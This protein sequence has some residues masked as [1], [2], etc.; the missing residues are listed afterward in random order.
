ME[1]HTRNALSLG[2]AAV[3]F[4]AGMI[5]GYD[6]GVNDGRAQEQQRIEE[7]VVIERNKCFSDTGTHDNCDRLSDVL[8]AVQMGYTPTQYYNK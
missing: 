8:T 4:G 2:V 7:T 1:K 6:C 5:I 3:E